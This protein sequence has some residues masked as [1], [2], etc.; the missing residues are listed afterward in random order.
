MVEGDLWVFLIED[1]Y[2]DF[3]EYI[4][5]SCSV[6]AISSG[7]DSLDPR[8]VLGSRE[9]GMGRDETHTPFSSHFVI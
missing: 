3:V 7:W 2:S 5:I 8:E 1:Y 9:S 6:E 4:S